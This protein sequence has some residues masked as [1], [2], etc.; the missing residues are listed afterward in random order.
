MPVRFPT[1][2]R[3]TVVIVLILTVL[4]LPAT[5]VAKKTPSAPER[6]AVKSLIRAEALRMGVPVSL[7]LAVAH[8]ESYFNPRAVSS[9]G[10]RG[11][12]QIMP[13]TSKGEYGIHPKLLWV[14]RVNIR[15]GLHFLKRLLKRYR[16]RAELALSYYNGGSAVGDLP[17]ARIIPATAKYVR[18]VLRLQRKYRA[19]RGRGDTRTWTASRRRNLLSRRARAVN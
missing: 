1:K 9:A 14:P 7:A 15:I 19:D 16:G 5:T 6:T 3:L 4:A 17:N 10:A 8:T 18:K 2:Q 11:V 12:M 13:A